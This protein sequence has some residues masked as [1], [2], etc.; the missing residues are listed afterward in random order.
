MDFCIWYV[1]IGVVM[2]CIMVALVIKFANDEDDVDFLS[3]IEVVVGMGL[4]WPVII[5]M[6][7]G[8]GFAAIRIRRI[9]GKLHLG[10][11]F[12]DE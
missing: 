6:L 12:N 10:M 3:L 11:A 9:D 5:I 1:S 8:F 4:F 7:V 2:G